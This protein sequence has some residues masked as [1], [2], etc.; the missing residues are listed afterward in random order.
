MVRRQ[1]AE[2]DRAGEGVVLRQPALGPEEDVEPAPQPVPP[3]EDVTCC[4]PV[5]G[6][7]PSPSRVAAF[8]PPLSFDP[9]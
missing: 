8:L 6:V 5:Q 3:T 9:S 2:L 1:H 4:H 7:L